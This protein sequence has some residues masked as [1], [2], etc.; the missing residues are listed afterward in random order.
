MAQ[1]RKNNLKSSI[2]NPNTKKYS[3]EKPNI[4]LDMKSTSPDLDSEKY[5]Y[6]ETAMRIDFQ[7]GAEKVSSIKSNIKAFIEKH[8]TSKINRGFTVIKGRVSSLF[9][10]WG[11][12]KGKEQEDVIDL[13]DYGTSGNKQE[14]P[15]TEPVTE[16][17]TEEPTTE[18]ITEPVTEEP[19]TEEETTEPVTEEKTTEEKPVSST[20]SQNAQLTQELSN[21]HN[22]LLVKGGV[23]NNVRTDCNT[24]S[25]D[26]S[27]NDNHYAKDRQLSKKEREALI[28]LAYHEAYLA[29][30][31]VQ[32]TGVMSAFLNG[33]EHSNMSFGDYYGY[34]CS[35]WSDH[36]DFYYKTSVYRNGSYTLSD[37]TS[38]EKYR[39]L[40]GSAAYDSL[41]ACLDNVM[42]GT[43]NNNA[44]QWY[45][46]GSSLNVKGKHVDVFHEPV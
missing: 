28:Y 12:L 13:K 17:A 2:V 27:I 16:P 36:D 32:A 34:S 24:Y 30:D 35:R 7:T 23:N 44:T 20:P 9:Q 15:K 14:E 4:S 37:I 39:E 6:K 38:L 26:E 43:R 18:P 45:D 29:G 19:T 1:P 41:N 22:E 11:W 8:I 5:D 10:K 40:E 31:P 21:R 46:D 3:Y 25:Y 42:A 33:W